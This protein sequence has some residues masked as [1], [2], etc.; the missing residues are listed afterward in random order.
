MTFM[1]DACALRT[2]WDLCIY[3]YIVTDI[4]FYLYLCS[5]TERKSYF[6]EG[7]K[8]SKLYKKT[9]HVHVNYSFNKILLLSGV[10]A[11]LLIPLYFLHKNTYAQTTGTAAQMASSITKI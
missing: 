9:F 11:V 7:M 2:F 3:I 1:I 8:V 10:C 4:Y 5:T 6:W